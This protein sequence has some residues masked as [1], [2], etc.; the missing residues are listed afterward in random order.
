MKK[1]C[2][3]QAKFSDIDLSPLLAISKPE[4][5]NL[6]HSP[7]YHYKNENGDITEFFMH[8]SPFNN[9]RILNKIRKNQYNMVVFDPSEIFELTRQ[10]FLISNNKSE[11]EVFADLSYA[12]S[13]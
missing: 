13:E 8:I 3:Y 4:Y 6:I 12:Q 11:A 10:Q 5:E 1:L 7:L 2:D 9:D